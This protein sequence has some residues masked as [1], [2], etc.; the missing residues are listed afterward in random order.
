MT[1]EQRETYIQKVFDTQDCRPKRPYL[2]DVEREIPNVSK[3][4]MKD[5][6]ANAAMILDTEKIIGLENDTFCI[7]DSDDSF[8]VKKSG[9][10]YQC[11]C[12]M[13][14][15]NS[16][17]C[18]HVVVVCE[19]SDSLQQYLTRLEKQTDKAVKVMFRDLP[20]GSGR[21]P[22]AKKCR[23]SNNIAKQPILDFQEDSIV[24]P[25]PSIFTE[26]YHNDEKFEVVFIK[27]YKNAKQCASCK[28]AI[29]REFLTIPFDIIFSHK[30]HYEYP[31]TD[32]K[33]AIH[34][35]VT[36]ISTWTC[37]VY[38]KKMQREK[39]DHGCYKFVETEEFSNESPPEH[40][41]H[42]LDTSYTRVG[43][44]VLPPPL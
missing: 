15:A 23:G 35:N 28:N 40:P 4:H 29:P 41:I 44:K 38:F 18:Q 31:A 20:G 24:N 36:F 2:A 8:I 5:I 33:G 14:K 37:Y 42:S 32:D 39:K 12:P 26:Y 11:E 9:Q 13:F 10:L 19:N 25:R 3:A 6:W 30:E 22:G 16:V 7:T 34:M 17:L 21:K 43:Q 27:D 1:P